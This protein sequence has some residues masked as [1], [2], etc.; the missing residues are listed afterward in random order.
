MLQLTNTTV[1]ASSSVNGFK[2][3][4]HAAAPA[5]KVTN[6]ARQSALLNN[7]LELILQDHRPAEDLA[8][9]EE[10]EEGPFLYL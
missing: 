10:E 4:A 1:A 9:R 6:L 3:H 7:M 5:D 2:P 8:Q